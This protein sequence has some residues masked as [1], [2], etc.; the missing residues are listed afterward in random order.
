VWDQFRA[1]LR[2]QAVFTAAAAL[3]A[4]WFAGTHGAVSALLG[5]LIGIAGG[6]A[7]VRVASKSKG[8]TAGDAL[9]VALKAEGA[10]LV[11]MIVLVVAVLK[12][13]RQGVALIVIG[14]FVVSALIFSIGAF[15]GQTDLQQKA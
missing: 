9:G 2:L 13:Y 12:G 3:A 14:S 11:L 8:K 15:A 1:A 4:G 6:L 10:K 5:G 7:F